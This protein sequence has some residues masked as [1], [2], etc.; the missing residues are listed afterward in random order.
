MQKHLG[1]KQLAWI[2]LGALALGAISSLALTSSPKAGLEFCNRGNRGRAI[3]AVAYPD[4][5]NGWVTEGWLELDEGECR[6]GISQVLSNR[7]Y[8]YFAETEKDYKWKGDRAFCVSRVKFT[9]AKSD[10]QCKGEKSRWEN[11][12][13]LDT[14]KDVGAYTLNLQ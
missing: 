14:G 13:E 1:Q 5:R 4:D 2:G 7:Y 12:R 10:Q 3:V 8:Y 9:F 6:T 11:F